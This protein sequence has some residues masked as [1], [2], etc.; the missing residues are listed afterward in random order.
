[1]RKLIKKILNL[2]GWLLFLLFIFGVAAS[3]I[4]NTPKVQT[5]I[6]SIAFGKI[7]ELFGSQV[8]YEKVHLGLFNRAEL[9]GFL[10]RDLNADTLIYAGKMKVKLPGIMKKLLF[11]KTIPLRI[12]ELS[13]KDSY[14]R[15]Y[16]DSSR[17]INLQFIVDKLKEGKKPG[18]TP[19]PL[20]I[21]QIKLRNCRLDIHNYYR[22]E[23]EFGIDYSQMTFR[24]LNMNVSDLVSFAD[25]LT[26]KIDVLSF[27]EQS[28]F[29]INDF[30][31]N[32]LIR[33]NQLYFDKLYLETNQAYFRMEHIY[34]DFDSFKDFSGGRFNEH[35]KMD[36]DC[37]ES[38]VNIRELAWFTPA[39]KQME[40]DFQLSGNFYGS[41]ANLRGRSVQLSY[42][43]STSL[44]GRFDIS[45]L[46]D[47]NE[48]FLIFDIDH[49]QT[50]TSDITRLRL[51]NGKT[52]K[53]P[54][55]FSGI[56]YY[57]YKG[58]FTGFFKDFVSYGTLITN[59]GNA[60][61]DVLF[62]PGIDNSVT[63]SGLVST[64]GFQIGPITASPERF[65]Q[66]DFNL[67]VEGSGIMDKG[68][69]VNMS[70]DIPSFTIN[71][72]RYQ[73]IQV[74]G[75]FSEKSFNGELEIDD[76]N[77]QMSFTGLLD[78]SSA[79]RQYNFS[80]H[81]YMANLSALNIDKKNTN[82][83]ASFLVRAS[84]SGNSPDE[85]NGEIKL[86]NALFSKSDAQIQLYD[87]SLFVRNDS[88]LNQI[89]FQSDF[90][91]GAISGH[92]KLTT[93]AKEYLRLFDT[94]L[95][96]LGL[97]TPDGKLLPDADFKYR[98]YFKN[99]QSILG[100]FTSEYMINPKTLVEGELKR[101][102]VQ[103]AT[104]HIESPE[105]RINKTRIKNLVLNSLAT[106]STIDIDFGCQELNVNKRLA[107]NNFTILTVID[108]NLVDFKAR[109]MNW[110]STMHRGDLE[111]KLAF[112]NLPGQKI[113]AEVE[114][115]SSMLV[116][117]DSLWVLHPFNLVYDS[118]KIVVQNFKLSH[119]DEYLQ[120]QGSLSKN[121]NDTMRCNFHNFNFGYLNF[122]TRSESFRFGGLVN[123]KAVVMGREK[124][125]FFASLYV[126]ALELND[127][128][129]GDTHIDT[130]Y[131]YQRESIEID[132]NVFRGNLN[133]LDIGGEYFPSRQGEL[134]L[135]LNLD[136]FRL[137]FINP[138]LKS[139]FSDIRGLATG[140]LHLTGTGAKPIL[141][142]IL[143]VQKAAFTVDYLNT[144][145]NFTSEVSF[146]NNNIVFDRVELFDKF[147]NTAQLNGIIRTEYLKT[148]S[149]NLSM[150][151]RNFYCL[152]TTENE[153]P[154]FFGQAFASGLIRI[155]G[156]S[157]ELTFDITATTE[158]G[159]FFNI[160]LS[161]TEE[162]SEY[163]FI[164]YIQTDTVSSEMD[165]DE[166]KVNLSGLN[167][168]FNLNVTPAAEVNIIFD[169]TVGD[170]ITTQG[171]GNLRI[172]INPLGDFNMLGEYVIESGT[173]LFTLK[174]ML[175]NKKFKV[176]QG[177]SLQWTGD[178]VNANV[179]INTYYRTKASMA[180]LTG[181]PTATTRYTVDCKLSL[182]GRLMN[183]L[184]N[185]NIFL[186]FSEQEERDVL[187][188]AIGSDEALGKQFLSL[189]VL[190]R[191]MYAGNEP[192]AEKGNSNIAGVNAS[193]F[194]T[195]QLSNWL[196]QISDEFDFGVNYRPGSELSP[197]EL[198]LALSTQLLNDRLTINGSVD[199]KTNAEAEDATNILGNLD[200]DYKITPNG[201][202]RARA[203]NRANDEIV[204]YSPYTQGIG[205]FYTEEFDSLNDLA[206]KN[207]KNKKSK[208][209]KEKKPEGSSAVIRDE[210]QE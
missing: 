132:A 127:E 205:V 84:L 29:K 164:K 79:I 200:V 81:V 112:R 18:K 188:A 116:L 206:G 38:K 54:E 144:R 6:T 169:P 21:D 88:L 65:G 87:F 197:Q 89:N 177:S 105:V 182:T 91:E 51:P 172:G 14:F 130:R 28:G 201:K 165:K 136:K 124:P 170:I 198:E 33:S 31:S 192:D 121:T 103:E 69:S 68:L 76:P 16:S 110:D 26:M 166:Y 183:P 73:N 126:Q 30:G 59:L 160:P 75:S 146:T 204:T 210:D 99:V 176:E 199:M 106:Q 181:D 138:Y 143:N 82:S 128:L 78:L 94:Y 141:N 175:L 140:K 12:G 48:T 101:G 158:P 117:G 92:Y 95:P 20:Y 7:Q 96:S 135:A 184:I 122:F 180:D 90:A 8:K 13:F 174:E 4:I 98:F 72:Y 109:W 155:N 70:G 193:E 9:E 137:N 55:R 186:P 57:T 142:G 195:N 131:N 62:K 43:S 178:P 52:I 173:Y 100:Y 157:S 171:T 40:D 86:V 15:L 115:D 194:L 189:L 187:S 167:L 113:V 60:K 191:F 162:L 67:K 41:L 3:I 19:E 154:Y 163:N 114:I 66:I 119:G 148:F 10:I 196:S 159:T 185:Y 145:Y 85:V 11:D 56:E 107:L 139:I 111:G 125:L 203:Y 34:F 104:I 32:L 120:A 150:Q 147:G 35:I 123:G 49:F 161:D 208:G 129:I 156:P 74:D 168:N 179:N 50:T 207:R 93:L 63:F 24:E 37:R 133:T 25:T 80:S 102:L 23:K 64:D 153:N 27:L 53:L 39:F 2:I 151:P 118:S 149:L 47:I 1:M 134:D 17:V 46:P 152:N 108:S 71:G 190:N 61:L 209:N 83:K 36:I 22:Q 5:R 45:G 77:L 42:G 58:N 97:Y 202:F 44:K